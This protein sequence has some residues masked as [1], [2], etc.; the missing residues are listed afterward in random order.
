MPPRRRPAGPSNW[1]IAPVATLLA[2]ALGTAGRAGDATPPAGGEPTY[3]RDVAPLLR[4]ECSGCHSPGGATPFPLLT[5]ADARKRAAQI[6]YVTG[7]RLMPPWKPEPG[8]GDFLDAR[9]LTEAQISLIRRWADAGAPL[10]DPQ[11]PVAQRTEPPAW[12]LGTPDLVLTVAPAY[13]VPAEEMD[14]ARSFALPLSLAEDRWVRAVEFRPGNPRVVRHARIDVAR[15]GETRVLADGVPGASWPKMLGYRL[16]WTDGLGTWAPGTV[17][18]PYALDAARPIRKGAELILTVQYHPSGRVEADQSSVGL[19]FAPREPARV[20]TSVPLGAGEFSVPEGASRFVVRDSF[21]L[22]VDM[23][24][25]GITPHAHMLCREIAAEA[26]LPNGRALALLRIR[27]WDPGWQE[28]YRYAAP[29]RLPAGTRLD[30]EFTYDNSAENPRN[31]NNP[32]R[33]VT[34]GRQL[35]D[36]MAGLWLHASTER[37]ADVERLNAALRR[38]SR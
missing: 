20:E 7:R 26:T 36:E 35:T 32:P 29:L 23:E 14:V 31:P 19:Y 15:R 34:A 8:A 1:A 16:G 33:R 3:Y 9:R 10:G 4:R 18:R 30:A 2:C 37:A 11:A 17:P 22:P 24:A 21:T 28:A 38:R 27:D 5:A 6:V 13:A 12:Q 25:V